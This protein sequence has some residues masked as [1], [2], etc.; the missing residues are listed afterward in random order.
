MSWLIITEKDN[1]ARRIASILFKDVKK[2]KK[3]RVTYYHSPSGDAYVVGLKGHIVELDFPKELNNWSKTPLEKL[4]DVKFVRKIKEKT[5][6][7]ILK[8]LA[9]DASRVTIATDYDREGELIGVEALE[10]VKKVNPNVKV[11][12]VKYSAVTEQEIKAA[13]SKP[14]TVDFNLA[15]A[16][17]ARQKID[18]IWGATLTRLVSVHSGRMGKDF[19]SVGR[20]QTPTLRLIVDRELEIQGFKPEKYYEIFAEFDGFVARHPERY[21]NR[22]EAEKVFSAIG[23]MAEVKS[24]SRR[25]VE[26]AKPIPFNTTE[27]LREA[28]KFMSPHKAMSIAETLYMNG[29]I[30]YPRTDNTVYPKTL[31]I[32]GIVKSLAAVFPEADVVLRQEKIIP[33]RG[34]RET[35]DHPP[36][37]PTGVASKNE[38]SKDEWRIY[39]LVVRRFL[40]TLAPKAV[41][42]VRKADLESNGV[43]FVANGRTLLEKGWREI[44]IYSKV[45]ETSL[46]LLK[47]GEILKIHKKRLEEK[48][49][50]PPHRFSAS[51][52][53]KAMERLNLGTK[54]TRHEI[55]QKLMSR[56]YIHGNP[57]R[58][59]ET[60]LSVINVLKETAET[61]TLPDMTAKL[62]EEMDMIAEGK[63]NELEVVQDSKNMLRQILDTIDYGKLSR[64]LKEGIKKDKVL[65]KCPECEGELVLRKSKA[66]KRFIG[67]SNYPDCTFTL[68]LPQNGTL[69]V[70]SKLCREHGIKE[71]KIRTKKG[72][73][74]LGC[75]YCNYLRWKENSG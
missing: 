1:T 60:A 61:I 8:D 26:E 9:K 13:F 46:P 19:L 25:K 53:I 28:S 56:G 50:K 63:K 45:E 18:L 20:V 64:E 75:P 15:N 4:L 71:V 10:M 55:I 23:E 62:E 48:E 69:Y 35:K 52:L 58:P 68:P 49:T 5:I 42:D 30:S 7:S 38:L 36:I 17:L 32:I 27:F 44:Y 34:R 66:K 2:L 37:Y 57:F 33:S 73:W 31:N 70:T 65:G 14:V 59:S 22:E 67:C 12:R 16:A 3:G 39:E 21:S 24:F 6:S 41:W 40:A 11:D 29:Y 54:S 43:R 51:S 74:N 72:Y 47:K